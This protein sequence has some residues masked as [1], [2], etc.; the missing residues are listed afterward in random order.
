[1]PP[2]SS[3]EPG[4]PCWVDLQAPD[5]DA[6]MS[7][8]TELFGWTAEEQFDD[9]G[10]RIYVMFSQDGHS[11]AGLGPQPPGMSG[12]PAV[13]TTYVAAA[14]V[15]AVAE[16]ARSAGG[17]VALAPMDVV[18]A[19]RMA[20]LVDPTGA[21]VAVWQ[22]RAH[23]GAGLVNEPNTLTWN[24][25]LTRDVATAKKFYA[26]VFGWGYE[27]TPTGERGE[28]T[29]LKL[30]GRD[31]GGL[32]AMPANVPDEAPNHWNVYFA[33]ADTN[34]LAARVEELGGH[35]VAGPTDTPVGRIATLHDPQ[36]GSFSVITPN[37]PAD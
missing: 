1:M 22:P 25:L 13:W 9:A 23:V 14:D 27:T 16:R 15:D 10:T 20:A 7:F 6:A 17:Q 5:V 2:R 8:Y 4:C 34:A 35:L 36:G 37:Q 18:D 32:M 21:T 19:G 26:A 24:E 12:A 11:V 28:Y 30:D 29:V 33:V 31:V 3:Y